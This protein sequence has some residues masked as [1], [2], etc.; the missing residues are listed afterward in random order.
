[1][2]GWEWDAEVEAGADPA[3][4]LELEG[5]AEELNLALSDGEA[6]AGAALVGLAGA[7]VEGFEDVG[8]FG[9]GNAESGVED[10]EEPVMRGGRWLRADVELDF[11]D[12]GEL[13]G[14]ADEVD[15]DL[16]KFAFV[17]VDAEG[18]FGGELE[19]E[20]EAL[21]GAEGAEGGLDTGSEL[22]EVKIHGVMFHA[23][24][25]D[26]GEVEHFV[27]ES[28]DVLAAGLDAEGGVALVRGKGGVPAHQL[29]VAEDGVQGGADFVTHAGQEIGLGL[30]GGGGGGFGALADGDFLL[31]GGVGVA[32]IAGAAGG[33]NEVGAGGEGEEEADG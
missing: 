29:G 10:L 25:L 8:L 3:L 19:A 27:D 11:A 23:T 1:V 7:L 18:R 28:E 22:A 20:G 16:A 2:G 31:E 21:L 33:V 14:V 30:V 12:A 9:F 6:E 4:G 5:T 26:F 17:A 15:E 13:D 24:G 32:D